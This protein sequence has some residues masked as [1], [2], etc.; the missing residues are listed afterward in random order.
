MSDQFIRYR[1]MEA[2]MDLFTKPQTYGYHCF[3]CGRLWDAYQVPI[4][5]DVALRHMA[6]NSTCSK[7]GSGR[8]AIVMP[9]RYEELKRGASVPATA[10]PV[11]FDLPDGE[12]G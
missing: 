6:A 9:H 8:I 12:R 4:P 3:E 11:G 7:C 1:Q 5:M 10:D 2:T